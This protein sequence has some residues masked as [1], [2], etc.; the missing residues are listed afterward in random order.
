MLLQAKIR[1]ARNGSD[2]Q[3]LDTAR[4]QLWFRQLPKIKLQVLCVIRLSDINQYAS[5]P[6]FRT[7]RRRCCLGI[8]HDPPTIL[9]TLVDCDSSHYIL[10]LSCPVSVILHY[11]L[12]NSYRLR[13]L[14]SMFV[15]YLTQ[16]YGI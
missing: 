4:D 14:I 2:N 1:D 5:K 9:L 6:C 8:I 16:K 12:R 7:Y 13:S 10:F 15:V 11:R 3:T